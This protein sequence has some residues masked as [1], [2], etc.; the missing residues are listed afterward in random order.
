MLPFCRSKELQGEHSTILMTFI[1]LPF[2][3]KIFV[4]SIFEWPLKTGFTLLGLIPQL[5]FRPENVVCFLLCCI[6]SSALQTRFIH[7]CKHLEPR[8]ESD[9]V[10]IV[11]NIGYLR[12][13]LD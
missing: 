10:H 7:G 2:V 5:F 8:S 3:M 9:P 13:L 12:T 1:K 11:N 6:Y 4:L